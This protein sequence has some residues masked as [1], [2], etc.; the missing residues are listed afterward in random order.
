MK[1]RLNYRQE[2]PDT[3]KAIESLS[4]CVQESGLEH[5]LLELIKTRASQIN[6]S[7]YCIDVHTRAARELGESER[8][9]YALAAWREAPFYT[10]RERAAL[11]R[12]EAVTR[13]ADSRVPDDLYEQARKH[14]DDR[15]LAA[16]TMAVVLINATN[17]LAVAFRAAPD[18]RGQDSGHPPQRTAS[19]GRTL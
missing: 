19:A 17:R 7:T 13:V 6:A 3:A 10:A 11:A 14:F 8:R 15:Q 9:L 5:R 1:L 2:A 18:S 16:L 4:R 12:T